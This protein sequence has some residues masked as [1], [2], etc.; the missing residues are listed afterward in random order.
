VIPAHLYNIAAPVCV[1]PAAHCESTSLLHVIS[2]RI[3]GMPVPIYVI[4]APIY[5]IPAKAG[6]QHHKPGLIVE[7][8]SI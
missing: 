3:P 6:I 1:I 4:S 7:G 5:V 8:Y 2:T